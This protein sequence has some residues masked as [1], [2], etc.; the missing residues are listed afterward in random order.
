MAK[1]RDLKLSI[2]HPFYNEP[3]RL[4]THIDT[5]KTYSQEMLDAVTFVLVDDGSSPE[6][7]LWANFYRIKVPHLEVYRIMEDLKWNTPGALNLGIIQAPTDWVLFM[8]SDC[9]MDPEDVEKLLN[10]EPDPSIAYYFPRNRVSNSDH[11]RTAKADRY[12]PCAVLIRKDLFYAV[13]GFDEDFT[14]SRSG[15][16]AMFDND[17][18]TRITEQAD[19]RILD[20]TAGNNSRY[21]VIEDTLVLPRIVIQEYM[22][23][24]V[25]PNIQTRD[26][27]R[28]DDHIDVNKRLWYNKIGGAV[29]RNTTHLNFEWVRRFSKGVSR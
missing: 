17:F 19:C 11:V 22:E 29:P 13:G 8:D 4:K 3:I 25:G 23:D 21:R 5:W 18:T 20:G 6:L 14:G 10:F 28:K 27:I 12:L 9:M 24:K 26:D 2:I 1:L 16:Y 7:L 15:G